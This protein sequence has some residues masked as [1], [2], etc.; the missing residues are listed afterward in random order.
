MSEVTFQT[1]SSEFLK[2]LPRKTAA[3]HER[4]RELLLSRPGEASEEHEVRFQE[5]TREI[6]AS[7]RALALALKRLREHSG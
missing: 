2:R 3:D 5:R 4:D 7:R 1:T 6:E